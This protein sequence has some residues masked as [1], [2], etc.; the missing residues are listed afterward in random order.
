MN[1]TM[2]LKTVE[3]MLH[4]LFIKGSHINSFARARPN[5]KTIPQTLMTSLIKIIRTMSTADF[6]IFTLLTR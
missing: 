6:A 2:A 1:I 5:I 3:G 4:T